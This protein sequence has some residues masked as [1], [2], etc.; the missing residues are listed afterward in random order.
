M[1]LL[2]CRAQMRLTKVNTLSYLALYADFGL[3]NLCARSE[4]KSE[5]QMSVARLNDA[6][7]RGKLRERSGKKF[8]F[9]RKTTLEVIAEVIARGAGNVLEMFLNVW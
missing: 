8:R 1:Q 7:V 6:K 3:S 9:D 4:G 2:F 5:W